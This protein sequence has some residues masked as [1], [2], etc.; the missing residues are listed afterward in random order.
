MVDNKKNH[1]GLRY[2]NAKKSVRDLIVYYEDCPTSTVVFKRL[3]RSLGY[4]VEHA[5]TDKELLSFIQ[6]QRNQILCVFLDVFHQSKL[7]TEIAKDIRDGKTALDKDFPIAFLSSASEKLVLFDELKEIEFIQKPIT[8]EK[9]RSF[10]TKIKHQTKRDVS[11]VLMQS[12]IKEESSVD[13]S[14]TEKLFLINDSSRS[15][16]YK[17]GILHFSYFN[18]FETKRS[19]KETFIG[20]GIRDYQ[21]L[22][23]AISDSQT[24]KE[25]I[26]L[27]QGNGK[28]IEEIDR[29]ALNF[30]QI[31]FSD[32][33]YADFFNDFLLQ[34]LKSPEEIDSMAVKA[35]YGDIKQ[36][37]HVISDYILDSARALHRE[38]T[39]EKN[40]LIAFRRNLS[41]IRDVFLNFNHFFP[42]VINTHFTGG[43]FHDQKEQ[44][45]GPKIKNLVREFRKSPS[46][47]LSKFLAIDIFDEKIDLHEYIDVNYQNVVLGNFTDFP[48]IMPKSKEFDVLI[49][50]RSTSHLLEQ[51]FYS[52]YSDLLG[53]MKKAALFLSDGLVESY[54]RH[55]RI[56]TI[57]RLKEEFPEIKICFFV[58]GAR[59]V[60]SFFYRA[61]SSQKDEDL[62]L[63]I[64]ECKRKDLELY[65]FENYEKFVRDHPRIAFKQLVIQKILPIVTMTP[66]LAGGKDMVMQNRYKFEALNEIL[67]KSFQT[68]FKRKVWKNVVAVEYI[69]EQLSDSS[70]TLMIEKVKDLADV[71][72]RE[73]VRKIDD[74]KK[75]KKLINKEI[76]SQPVIHRQKEEE[77]DLLFQEVLSDYNFPEFFRSLFLDEWISSTSG[78]SIRRNSAEIARIFS[79]FVDTFEYK[80]F[81]QED[82]PDLL[83]SYRYL[84]KDHIIRPLLFTR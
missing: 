74:Y 22:L 41:L 8:A 35:S 48:D 32:K 73:Y 46:D 69:R 26:H 14:D 72:V 79:K 71:F 25:L 5:L 37:F 29:N 47:F 20:L 1:R 53:R 19:A 56:N 83:A 67:E 3:A 58:S 61:E 23:F 78:Q 43:E 60:S 40:P 55:L 11:E 80:I 51:D 62:K 9:I 4:K 84:I 82:N 17:S 57:V 30:Q 49:A 10:I 45:L 12:R 66:T 68:F 27:G 16:L 13:S 63:L 77:F 64:S 76:F 75:Y 18:D 33:I 44:E 34:I 28:I 24:T 52:L 31:G 6:D 21:K 15:D 2:D 59:V 36:F 7:G 50:R 65:E 54:T 38:N 70:E 42:Q 39:E 81:S